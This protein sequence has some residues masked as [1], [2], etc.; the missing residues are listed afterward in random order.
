MALVL[1]FDKNHDFIDAIYA[2][3][4]RECGDCI[5][6]CFKG[7]IDKPVLTHCFYIN[8][9]LIIQTLYE[10]DLPNKIKTFLLLGGLENA[11]TN[12]T[13]NNNN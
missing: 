1:R 7:L 6:V 5:A 4:V 2:E 9:G 11:I 10:Q 13:R 12:L 8:R 3:T